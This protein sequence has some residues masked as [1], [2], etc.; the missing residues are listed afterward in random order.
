MIGGERLGKV[1]IKHGIFQGDILSPFLF[2]LSLTPMSLVLH[3]VKADLRK[4]SRRINH[5]S[6]M[7]DLKSF[8]K[9]EIQLDSLINMVHIYSEDISMEF[10]LR[11]CG[12]LIMQRGKLV[13]TVGMEFPSSEKI[14][15]IDLDSGYKYLGIWK[16]I[17]LKILK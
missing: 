2:V 17:A 4:G 5:L 15:E 9:T 1:T 14:K 6:H 16:H 13:H 12:I 11:K 8:G 10:G 3:K 7:D